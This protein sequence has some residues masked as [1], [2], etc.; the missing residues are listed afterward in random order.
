MLPPEKVAQWKA[1]PRFPL[2]MAL[3]SG[4]LLGLGWYA[5]FTPL[6]F[7]GLVPVLALEDLAWERKWKSRRL[8]LWLWISFM[9]W[10]VIVTWWLYNA[11]GPLYVGIT[12]IKGAFLALPVWLS[13]RTR[14]HTAGLFRYLP[15]AFYWV[16]WEWVDQ[17]WALDW[18]WLQLGN[19]FGSVPQLVQW[20]EVTGPQGGSLWVLLGNFLAYESLW[21]RQ[22]KP[23]VFLLS[24]VLPIAVSLYLYLNFTPKEET[25]EVVVV[26]P[27]LDCY[28]EKFKRN[29]RTG[30]PSTNYVPYPEQVQ[31]YHDIVN[32]YLT[33]ETDYIVFPETSFH[34]DADEKR[35]FV[36]GEFKDW[37][38]YL[39]ENPKL[40]LITGLDTYRIFDP[41]RE[42]LPK[43]VRSTPNGTHYEKYNAA[44]QLDAR[45]QPEFYHKSKLVIGAETNPLEGIAGLGPMIFKDLMGSLGTQEEREVFTSAQGLSVA[46]V[47]CYESV[48]GEFVGEYI[49]EGAEAIFVITNDGWWGDTPGHVQHLNFSR[50]R[51]LEMRR[52]VA[53]AANTGISG[54]INARGDLLETLAYGEQGAVRGKIAPQKE[55]TFYAQHGDYLG[56][57][58]GFLGFFI[59]I[60]GF[61]RSLREKKKA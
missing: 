51:A 6:L 39:K 37:L 20:Y 57:L 45:A 8:F 25:V 56:R 46:P 40:T 26:Q 19:A 30:E 35:L 4:L 7:V 31:R 54:F 11:V 47:I 48:Y 42:E 41:K 33:P 50:L 15:F 27:N 18:T 38:D 17:N 23:G 14:R 32:E 28:A 21:K 61:T 12:L 53:R 36:S 24:L 22:L 60:S 1:H 59:F 29:P 44:L 52:P 49:Q 3:L 58:A 16:A 43:N 9:L 10:H 34:D 2:F 55:I 13:F 5:P